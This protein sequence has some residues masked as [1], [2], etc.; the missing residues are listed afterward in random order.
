M[1]GMNAGDDA[2]HPFSLEVYNS[3]PRVNGLLLSPDG[4]RL[5][6]AVQTLS[7]D[8]TR[9]V[10]S[11]WAMPA[12]GSAPA[13]RLTYSEK[14]EGGV[15]FLPD[16]SI[17]FTSARPDPTSKDD[18]GEG[19]LWRLPVG[20]GEA[21]PLLSL[22][23]G[24]DGL[25]TAREADVIAL[26]TSF[27]PG[28]DDLEKDAEKAKQRK[29]AGTSAILFDSYPIRHWDHHLG[30]RQSRL[31]RLPADRGE[32]PRDLEP[33][34]EGALEEAE[35]TI[36]PDGATVVTTW[37]RQLGKAFLESDLVAFG[38]DGRRTLASGADFG[39]PA[40]SPDG[41]TVAAIR[42]RPGTPDLATD[43]TLWLVDLEGG[44][45]TGRDATPELDLWP[46]SPAWAPDSRSIY[47]VADQRGHS[48]V[49]RLDLESGQVT[50]L[51]SEGAFGSLCPSPDGTCV[52]ALRS[53]YSSPNQVVRVGLDGSVEELP[54]PGLPL[55]LP[56]R[57]EEVTATAEDGTPLR[58]WLVLPHEASASQ[59]APL[60]LWIH[61]GPL[62]SWNSWSWRWCPHLAAERGYAV[63]LPDP[64]LSTGYGHAFI[65]RGWTSW[66]PPTLADLMAITDEA[67]K[68]PDL[69]ES[70]TAA[71]GGSFGGYMSNWVAGHTDR[72]KAIVTH[73]S[74]WAMDQF[75]GTTDLG[76]FWEHELGDPYVDG[77]RWIE[78]SPHRAI[79]NIKTPMLVIHGDRDYRVPIGEALRLWTDLRRH[80]VPAKF[81]FFPDENHWIL[82]P[83]NVQ[84]WYRTVLAFLDHH[85]LGKEWA[86][87]ELV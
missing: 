65:Q 58:A 42:E 75:H 82:K 38:S 19:R 68:R 62:S 32:A 21:E 81:L 86:Q 6:M 70:R 74:L 31:L 24:A 17:V 56:G 8:G 53:S 11:I 60:L 52:F 1:A 5:V 61:G 45:E 39:Q 30:P 29:D 79:G 41:R 59:P 66:G 12:D 27:F 67:L 20:G 54:T 4:T 77:R 22:P 34:P 76:T 14:G 44:E 23:A 83:G 78:S 2:A 47:F 46:G 87:P 63:L 43:M 50:Q 84:V 80:E 69:D 55:E 72:F 85:V 25:V 35:F 16:G 26:R 71:M 49:F 57:V 36:S 13:R 33:A 48:P 73:A 9:L 15:A 3:I 37:K 64:A 40:I 10:T 7:P 28:V 51:T 18:Q